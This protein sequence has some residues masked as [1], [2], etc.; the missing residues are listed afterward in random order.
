[1]EEISSEQEKEELCRKKLCSAVH[2]GFVKVEALWREGR[3]QAWEAYFCE[4]I[5]SAGWTMMKVI[6]LRM[7]LGLMCHP[8]LM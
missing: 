4:T 8:L 3:A 2:W 6:R 5:S 7:V 1:M